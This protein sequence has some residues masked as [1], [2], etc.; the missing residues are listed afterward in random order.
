[1]SRP[2]GGHVGRYQQPLPATLERDHHAVALALGHVAVQRLHA[3]AGV[4]E[5]AREPVHA[6]LGA[7]ED[8][9]LLGALLL[10]HAH[11]RVR[12]L[13]VRHLDVEVVDRVDRERG[14]AHLD[15]HRVVHERVRQAADLRRNRRAEE[16]GLA[17]HRRA[18]ED[19]LHVLEEAEVQ[20]LVGLVE[21][22]VA[23]VVEEEVV[24][25]D[26]VHHAADRA[27]HDLRVLQARGLVADRRAAEHRHHVEALLL[28]VGAQRLRHLDAE[29]ARRGEHERLDARVTRVRV[30]DHRQAERGGLAGARLRLADHVL[31]LRSARGSPAPGSASGWCSPGG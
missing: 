13:L 31:P 2:A 11:E 22:D 10:Q 5:P 19:R 27:D 3:H 6:D 15:L 4:A 20:H 21:H 23:G 1:M 28:A 18:L 30:L 24:A 9:R 12:L 8:D 26:H 25:A 7:H 14:R 16:P 29:L 17:A